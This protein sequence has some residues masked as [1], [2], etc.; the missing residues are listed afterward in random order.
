MGIHW[1]FIEISFEFQLDFD[2]KFIVIST[3]CP[4]DFQCNFNTVSTGFLMFF[5]RI[6]LKFQLN[7]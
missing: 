2:M 6:T 3:E 5:H 4:S 7:L 1:Y